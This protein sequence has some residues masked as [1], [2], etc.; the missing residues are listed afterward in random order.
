M[1]DKIYELVVRITTQLDLAR[2]IDE[3]LGLLKKLDEGGEKALGPGS[4]TAQGAA[5]LANV[6]KVLN[7]ALTATGASAEKQ[8]SKASG[9]SD[10]YR[11]LRNETAAGTEVQ[12][13][14][15]NIAFQL[16]AGTLRALA[17]TKD[18]SQQMFILGQAFKASGGDAAHF[19]TAADSVIGT[20]AR[21]RIATDINAL[22][23]TAYGKAS[24]GAFQLV[25]LAERELAVATN[26]AIS[27]TQQSA[28]AVQAN[29]IQ[30]S[31]VLAGV[32]DKTAAG[33]KAVT[34]SLGKFASVLSGGTVATATL[35]DQLKG[36]SSE[37]LKGIVDATGYSDRVT[38]LGGALGL[39]A[40]ATKLLAAESANAA[41]KQ[42]QS[43]FSTKLAE[44]AQKALEQ[45]AKATATALAE[46]GERTKTIFGEIGSAVV[47]LAVRFERFFGLGNSAPINRTAT[48]AL[49]GAKQIVE[50]FTGISKA[51]PGAADGIGRVVA[52]AGE[53]PPVLTGI[54][55]DSAAAST[56]IGAVGISAGAV[57]VGIAAVTGAV[58]AAAASFKALASAGLEASKAF[59]IVAL[60]APKDALEGLRQQVFDISGKT[61]IAFE[62]LADAQGRALLKVG[63]DADKAAKLLKVAADTSL[64]A[65]T[66]PQQAVEQ[67]GDLMRNYGLRIDEVK[68]ASN[69]LL[70]LQKT[71]GEDFGQLSNALGAAI[72][73]ARDLSIDFH[74]LAAAQA[75]MAASGLSGTQAMYGL[76]TVLSNIANPTTN[77]SVKMRQLGVDTSAQAFSTKGLIPVLKDMDAA[78]RR[79]GSSLSA[80]FGES[81]KSG[82]IFALLGEGG[83]KAADALEQMRSG[84]DQ[85]KG[86]IEGLNTP[87]RQLRNLMTEI[88]NLAPK[89]G[90]A[91]LN[92]FAPTITASA[93]VI[94]ELNKILELRAK[95]AGKEAPT[96]EGIAGEGV[97][98]GLRGLVPGAS[99][100]IETLTSAGPLVEKLNA[101]LRRTREE[102]EG[103]AKAAV[104]LGGDL[105]IVIVP[106]VVFDLASSFAKAIKN[107]A[108]SKAL[109]D[110]RKQ[111]QQVITD[112]YLKR[113]L[114]FINESGNSANA[115]ATLT[116]RFAEHGKL[117]DIAAAATRNFATAAER[118]DIEIKR[119]ATDYSTLSFVF[120]TLKVNTDRLDEAFARW[121]KRAQIT[122]SVLNLSETTMRAADAATAS[123]AARLGLAAEASD[124]FQA[125]LRDE[126]TALAKRNELLSKTP[127]RTGVGG[128]SLAEDLDEAERVKKAWNSVKA[129]VDQFDASERSTTDILAAQFERVRILALRIAPIF[130]FL[131]AE[132]LKFAN[133]FKKELLDIQTFQGGFEKA[134]RST[135]RDVADDFKRGEEAA[136][137]LVSAYTD[138]KSALVDF[139]TARGTTLENLPQS[140][141]AFNAP[142]L[143]DTQQAEDKIRKLIELQRDAQAQAVRLHAEASASIDQ[144][145]RESLQS[146]ATQAEQAAI[147]FQRIIKLTNTLLDTTSRR[148]FGGGFDEGMHEFLNG[149]SEDFA[150]GKAKAQEFA[151]VLQRVRDEVKAFG[152]SKLT[153]LEQ[154]TIELGKLGVLAARAEEE[155]SKLFNPEDRR[156]M[157]QAA[158]GI[159]E[160]QGALQ[161][162]ADQQAGGFTSGFASGIE[163][164][165][166]RAKDTFRLGS[167]AAGEFANSSVDA[168]QSFLQT[169]GTGKSGMKAF[170]IAILQSLQQMI[171]KMLAF[172]IVSGILGLFTGPQLQGPTQA[173]PPLKAQGG[174]VEAGE[175]YI[176]GEKGPELFRAKQSGTI[177]PHA[178]TIVAL[179]GHAASAL[180]RSAPS[181]NGPTRTARPVRLARSPLADGIRHITAAATQPFHTGP[182]EDRARETARRGLAPIIRRAASAAV[183]F[184]T[185]IQAAAPAALT[186]TA[187]G[188]LRLLPTGRT[189][190]TQDTIQ[191]PRE[192]RSTQAA[193]TPRL[194]QAARRVAAGLTLAFA[195]AALQQPARAAQGTAPVQGLESTTAIASGIARSVSRALSGGLSF[196]A[197][198]QRP[199]GRRTVQAAP[200][201]V[202]TEAPSAPRLPVAARPA[203]PLEVIARPTEAA[204]ASILSAPAGGP[205]PTPAPRLQGPTGSPSGAPINDAARVLTAPAFAVIFSPQAITAAPLAAPTRASIA[206]PRPQALGR[207]TPI[208]RTG[209]APRQVAEQRPMTP[210]EAR[211]APSR[212]PSE[213]G[214]RLARTAAGARAR[215]N[216]FIAGAAGVEQAPG[217]RTGSVTRL[218]R[219]AGSSITKLVAAIP[220]FRASPSQLV[221]RGTSALPPR[222]A[223]APAQIAAVRQAVRARDVAPGIASAA[224]TI[225][226]RSTITRTSDSESSVARSRRSETSDSIITRL[227]RTVTEATESAA[228]LSRV[229]APQ[230]QTAPKAE[231]PERGAVSPTVVSTSDRVAQARAPQ[232][233]G[234]GKSAPAPTVAATQP[235]HGVAAAF[236]RQAPLGL[237]RG[238]IAKAF[239][240]QTVPSRAAP[241][242]SKAAAT[243]IHVHI[244]GI[245]LI[246]QSLDP[247]TAGDVILAQMNKIQSALAIAI[248]EGATS[249]LNAAIRRN[250]R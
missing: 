19:A 108:I 106:D 141:G 63:G 112:D 25:G 82:P 219:A 118:Q 40:A 123:L 229:V 64:A 114:T 77:I 36:L 89:I 241:A 113:Q 175:D 245:N 232:S 250:G 73:V 247:R 204:G 15:K 200:A 149:L 74:E 35:K 95:V 93:G 39:T 154:M 212:Q 1:A 186:P 56:S 226:S 48:Q 30:G 92:A 11:A 57:T 167:E 71:A 5:S 159:R 172:Q 107:P 18:F 142:V 50:G 248:E 86:P 31:S 153:P 47:G 202:S 225:R 20:M 98:K 134:L 127:Q 3:G 244:D 84:L 65:F 38:R 122:Q 81:R 155:A 68:D 196:P 53:V 66:T 231:T 189:P 26:K 242:E 139:A 45:R 49:R 220:S 99:L 115:L 110:L 156:R 165:V 169:L 207:L 32:F 100:F 12:K 177:I 51:A 76:R 157:E 88:G 21:Q 181:G 62:D 43:A 176:V 9:L 4:Q 23:V 164:F 179:G 173:G 238:A 206:A 60:R 187:R 230:Q 150:I 70:I 52:A 239:V 240:G 137:R 140:G 109:E 209:G 34:D 208:D 44:Q 117:E 151:D 235:R 193:G 213:L 148:G 119:Q 147:E 55:A 234:E 2:G 120:K 16:D 201:A 130:P 125:E 224:E 85:T 214:M 192:A 129:A 75:G 215:I 101:S 194:L 67:L 121:S 161:R 46:Q 199:L 42:G 116:A 160:T 102:M 94:S 97:K 78:L 79:D 168:M 135:F 197:Q 171:T 58:L 72:P 8:K 61:G 180:P 152:E 182:V 146:L 17:T 29:F 104:S 162:L 163:D 111:T 218:L 124:I 59:D 191:A 105:G 249:A 190:P 195:P 28:A 41:I 227:S 233:V 37:Q 174:P 33:E 27:E 203:S 138:A 237:D 236:N 83:K 216:D 211:Q 128:K 210:S 246:S 143:S 183:R 87:I 188:S 54:A 145:E 144:Q 221:P 158:Q 166:T 24:V 133:R 223:G 96:V 243:V 217:E 184:A 103:A 131:S 136:G 13:A 132:M 91:V 80:F 90:D 22:S 14:F 185:S 69:T 7:D 10:V 198:E 126:Y 222:P 170:E 228:K 205:R 178:Q 6:Q